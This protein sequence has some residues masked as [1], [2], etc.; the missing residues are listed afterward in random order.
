MNSRNHPAL[1]AVLVFVVLAVFADVAS[2]ANQGSSIL[3]MNQPLQQFRDFFTGTF[4]WT[5]S[6]IALVISG[7]TL[8][9]G[10]DISGWAKNLIL[11]AC[12]ISMIVFANNLL[13][14]AFSGALI[15]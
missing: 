8:A 10:A 6:I 11:L 14:T 5:V 12:V 2:A 3:P 4:A 7:T 1:F 13:S 15:A 9:F